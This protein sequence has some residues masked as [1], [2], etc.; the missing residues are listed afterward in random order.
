MT[1]V[2]AYAFMCN[3]STCCDQTAPL[4][5]RLTAMEAHAGCRINNHAGKTG[6]HIA[7]T[8]QAQGFL[9]KSPID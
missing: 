7:C 1:K 5:L 3:R 6:L 4:C 2:E 8:K 9:L